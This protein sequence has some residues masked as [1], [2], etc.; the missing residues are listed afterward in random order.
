MCSLTRSDLLLGRYGLKK[1]FKTSSL[2]LI[3]TCFLKTN[4]LISNFNYFSG[5]RMLQN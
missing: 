2:T 1:I 5:F 3:F 4:T